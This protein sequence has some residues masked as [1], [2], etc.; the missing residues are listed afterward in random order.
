MNNIKNIFDDRRRRER[1]TR[2]T[3]SKYIFN[4][5]LVMF[6]IIVLGAGLINYSQWLENA[7]KLEMKTVFIAA[8]AIFSYLLISLKVKTFI[9][10]AD[11][12][13]LLPLEKYYGKVAIKTGIILTTIHLLFLVIFYFIIKPLLSRIGGF[14]GLEEF[15]GIVGAQFFILIV[16]VM[17]NVFYRLAEAIY[18]ENKFFIKILLFL[19]IFL[20]I[21]VVFGKYNYLEYTTFV[22]LIIISIIIVKNHSNVKK[23]LLLNNDIGYAL[24]WNEA[25][26]YDRHREENYLKFVSMFVDV[27]LNGIKVARRKYFDILLPKLTEKNFTVKNSFKYYYYRVFLRQENTVFLA[28]RLMLIAGII[29]YSFNN[30]YVSLVVIISYSY[31][32]IIQLVPLYKQISNNIWHNILPVNEEIK[33]KSFKNLLTAVILITT[34]ILTLLSIVVSGIDYLIIGINILSFV[35][36]NLLARVFI[37]KVK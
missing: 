28:L 4:S 3:Y 37:A 23:T 2:V 19:N 11:A 18:F 12:I 29:I 10:E 7:S 32:T 15:T 24:K 1:E 13:F 20:P 16:G 21:L 33:I 30:V 17:V 9:K 27:P 36:A 22:I 26:E 34:F 25:A 31:L 6:L 8:S 14:S 5:H 35:L